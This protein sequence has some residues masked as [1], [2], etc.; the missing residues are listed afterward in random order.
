WSCYGDVGGKD[1]SFGPAQSADDR[2]L[3]READ[4]NGF[5]PERELELS[6][7]T[8]ALFGLALAICTP[9]HFDGDLGD[10]VVWLDPMVP[11][12]VVR[13][14]ANGAV[15]VSALPYEATGLLSGFWSIER[16]DGS[17]RGKIVR[18]TEAP[19]MNLEVWELVNGVFVRTEFGTL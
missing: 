11:A 13:F 2:I 10:F 12:S 14:E 5:G 9:V 6:G 19:N 1:V 16:P 18:A 8:T 7:D 3:I 15:S 17:G 4:E